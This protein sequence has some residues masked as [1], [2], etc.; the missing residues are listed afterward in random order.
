MA[1]LKRLCPPGIAQH[2]IQRGNNRQLC[3][4]CDEDTV[5]YV[6][7]LKEYAKQFNVQVH[8][9]V[10]MTNHVHLLATPMEKDGLS[11]LMQFLGRR[12]VQ[13]FNRSYRRTGT[14]WEGRFKSC[15]VQSEEYL[16]QCYRYI[17]LNP[18]RAKMVADPAE[19]K[20]SS[21]RANALGIKTDLCTPHPQYLALGETEFLRMVAYRQ[22]FCGQLDRK[23]IEEIRVTVNKGMALGNARFKQELEA[24]FSRRVQPGKPGRPA[25]F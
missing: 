10:L 7:W 24:L 19:Y 16:L 8:A 12:Y 23:L 4:G 20:W 22:L 18:V 13:Y 9:W 6:H 14:L 3:F 21:Y 2:V 1:R 5:F 15:L 11:K 17:E 25:G